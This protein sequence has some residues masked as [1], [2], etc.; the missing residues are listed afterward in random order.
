MPDHSPPLNKAES[1]FNSEAKNTILTMSLFSDDTKIIGMSEEIEEGKQIIEKVMGEFEERTKESKE[2]KM[3]FGAED[4]EEIRILGTYMGNEQDTE[5]QIKRA[6]RTWMQI[7]ERFG[8]L[9]SV[10]RCKPK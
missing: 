1:T 10:G 2:E 3:E 4:I 8:N 9:S 7:K 6:A 5:M